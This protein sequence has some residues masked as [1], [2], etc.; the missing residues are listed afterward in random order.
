[1]PSCEAHEECPNV[2]PDPIPDC[3]L[4]GAH[5]WGWM[6]P[7]ELS[8]LMARAQFMASVVEI[9]CLHGRSSYALATACGSLYCVDPWNDPGWASWS[10]SMAEF[11]HVV[12]IRKPSP[13]AWMALP[14]FVDMTFIDGDHHYASV[15]ADIEGAL[16]RTRKLICGHDYYDA[17]DAPDGGWQV[18]RAVDE[19]F[20]D[21]VQVA[22]LEG[23]ETSIWFVELA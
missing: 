14:P 10:A 3:R 11:D 23:H 13:E 21:R 20:G 6:S 1:M 12:P 8:W 19:V 4:P 5:L 7:V 16:P 17:P 15:K 22:S 9:G 18:K 2:Q